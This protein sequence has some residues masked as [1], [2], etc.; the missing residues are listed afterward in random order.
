MKILTDRWSLRMQLGGAVIKTNDNIEKM[1]REMGLQLITADSEVRR[2]KISF[3]EVFQYYWLTCSC[4]VFSLC[5]E[6]R[7]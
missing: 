3:K 2:P 4:L 6:D 1:F 7:Q 5:K